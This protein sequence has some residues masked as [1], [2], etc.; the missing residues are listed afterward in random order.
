[1]ELRPKASG[2]FWFLA[3]GLTV[4]A[5]ASLLFWHA[6]PYGRYLHHWHWKGLGFADAVCS[7]IPGGYWLAPA[8]LYAGSWI[9]MTAAMMLP[10]VLPLIRKFE[11]MTT[12][13][14]DQATLHVLLIVGYLLVWLAFGIAA[15]LGDRGLHWMASNFGWLAS[16]GWAASAAMLAIAGAFQFSSLKYQCLDKCRSP[17]AFIM[18]YW[19][20]PQPR[21]EA[22]TLGVAHGLYCVGCCWALMLLMF[23]VGMGSISWMF[24]LAIVM[25]MEKNHPWGRISAAPLGSCL[26]ATAAFLILLGFYGASPS[27]TTGP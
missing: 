5:W 26:L 12:A 1:M 4:L 14:Q 7:Q 27:R 25:A 9:L 2:P 11:G 20:G 3:I 15:H 16:D 23:L 17:I 8:A 18:G 13:R 21:R 10:T 24:A 19:H 6:S 22:F